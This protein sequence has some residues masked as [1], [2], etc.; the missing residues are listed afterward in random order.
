[1]IHLMVLIAR[2]VDTNASHSG[3]LVSSNTSVVGVCFSACGTVPGDG[4]LVGGN[5]SR[6]G[7]H[8]AC[9]GGLGVVALMAALIDDLTAGVDCKGLLLLLLWE[10][11][12]VVSAGVMEDW[13]VVVE[14]NLGVGVAGLEGV[15]V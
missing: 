3:R 6:V 5:E 7:I 14:R 2:P 8:D 12:I 10:G 9:T 4:R 11:G 13:E 1:M 15:L